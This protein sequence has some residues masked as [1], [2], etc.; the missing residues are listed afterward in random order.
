[1]SLTE[2]KLIKDYFYERAR[3]RKDV[4]LGIGDD[5]A[6]TK[7]PEGLM[8]ATTTDTLVSGVHFPE[9]T[10]PADLAIKS[11]VVNLSDLAAMGA[12]PAWLSL[13]LTLPK[14]DHEWLKRF[15]ESFF[16]QLDYFGLDLI[17][18][19]TTSGPLA[20]SITAMGFVPE[21]GALRRTNAEAGD[22]IYVTNTLGDAGLGL[23]IAQGRHITDNQ[24][25]SEHLL[26]KLNKP[27]PRL[28]VGIGIRHIANSAID[29]S[30]GLAGDLPHILEASGKG[31]V[32]ELNDLP[33]SKALVD[34]VGRQE[35]IQYAL[36]SGDDYEL[37]F[38]VPEEQIERLEHALSS[39]SCGFSCIG[40]ITGG[41]GIRYLE[42][43]EPVELEVAAYQHFHP[44]Q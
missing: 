11:I 21:T 36:A 42:K 25:N 43:G 6:L 5:C 26:T 33:L 13:S 28:A 8:L 32:I 10:D 15:S 12:E 17:G 41:H 39:T 22:R 16:E 2:F 37:C 29:L 1:M 14:S 3:Q 31:A 23:A 4:V 27:I 20:I 40:R 38:T 44:R 18:G 35:A 9:D 7:V 19:D 34:E 24:S 30:D